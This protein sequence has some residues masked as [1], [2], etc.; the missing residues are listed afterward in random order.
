[1]SKL[2]SSLADE[3][4]DVW[5]RQP[6]WPDTSSC[7]SSDTTY[8]HVCGWLWTFR[9]TVK[10]RATTLGP[11]DNRYSTHSASSS[12]LA[13]NETQ[14]LT[15]ISVIQWYIATKWYSIYTFPSCLLL[16]LP[17]GS[18]MARRLFVL[19][20]DEFH[21]PIHLIAEQPRTAKLVRSVFG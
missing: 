11:F 4:H 17:I 3:L 13:G 21:S 6:Q 18:N 7:S 12:L 20:N 15:Y 19:F 16:C 5:A 14:I 2:Q 1:M 10:Y 8:G 9:H